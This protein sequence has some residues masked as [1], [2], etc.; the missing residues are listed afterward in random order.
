MDRR[1]LVTRELLLT[2]HDAKRCARR[3]HNEWDPSVEQVRWEVPPELQMRFDA[4]N[5]FEEA[6]FADLKA[7]LGPSRCVDLCA[8]HG[9]A[10]AIAETVAAMK[11]GVAVILGGWLPDD[12]AGGRTGKPDLL[13][14]VAP[15]RYVP[16]DV[17]AHKVI[18][19]RAKG[20][21]TY[22]AFATPADQLQVDGLA[23]ATTARFD[24]Y[25]QLAHYWRMLQAI[26]RA[27]AGGAVGVIIGR[28]DVP[29]LAP[30]G[31]VLTWLDLDAPLFETYSRTHGKVKRSA[32]ERYDHEQRFRL[33][34]A[35]AASQGAQALVEPVFTDECDSCPWFDHCRTLVGDDLASANITAGRL[36][37]REW[38]ALASAG[39]VGI[40]DLADLDTDAEEFQAT[41]LPEVTHLE[42]PIG[43]LTDAVRRARMIRDGRV[44][45][46][47]TTG[48]IPVPRADIEIDFDIEWDPDDR[49]YLWGALVHRAGA[50]PTYHPVVSWAD[51]DDAGGVEHAEAFAAWLRAQIMAADDAGE[52][53][54]VYHYSHPEPTYLKRLLGEQAVADLTD[55]FVDLLA[56]VRE[57]Y[58]GVRGLGIKQV[59][60]AFG[61]AWRDN[62]PGGLQ[63]Q[64]WLIDARTSEDE[65]VRTAA[66]ERILAYNEDDVRATAALR[67]GL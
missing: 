17:K 8:V 14:Q 59:A 53:L 57:H 3:I 33:K 27:P 31:R 43:R 35:Q 12:A 40:E 19:R 6:I 54:L 10:Q 67:A 28:D 23:P 61:F 55:R 42:D 46:R 29:D 22:S 16:G 25:L 7:E 62:D 58:F 41:Y 2:G 37:V 51:L 47:T 50:E 34:V 60:P 30:N 26:D 32:L 64:L 49:V 45:E 15:G 20:A 63:S 9:K 1:I 4:G 65:A 66:R 5:L 24:D 48:S 56:I 36:S 13:L 39:V 21:L 44:I 18:A 11:A 38:T 52:S